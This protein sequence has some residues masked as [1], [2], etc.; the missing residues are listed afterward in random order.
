MPKIYKE[1][2]PVERYLKMTEHGSGVDIGVVDGR[3]RGL[4]CLV[5]VHA[6]NKVELI[7]Y[8]SA[9]N[10]GMVL[11]KYGTIIPTVD[12]RETP[13]PMVTRNGDR[14]KVNCLNNANIDLGFAE[15][16]AFSLLNLCYEMR[17][18]AQS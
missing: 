18:D 13:S 16:L 14:L 15:A 1:V 12:I 7:R 4:G 5:H 17:K 10:T 8:N 6:N 2:A 3:G 9:D 11:S